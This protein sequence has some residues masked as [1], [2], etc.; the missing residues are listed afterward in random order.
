MRSW[1]EAR[2]HLKIITGDLTG[3]TIPL[4]GYEFKDC[5][6]GNNILVYEGKSPVIMHCKT[7][8]G[9]TITLES[10]DPAILETEAIMNMLYKS[11]D[12]GSISCKP[13]NPNLPLFPN[14]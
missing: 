13:L 7:Q 11:S 2:G 3:R 9:T 5:T 14:D 8:E 6:I 1:E 10:S 4:D 12:P